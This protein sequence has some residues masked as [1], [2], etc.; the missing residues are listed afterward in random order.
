MS[1]SGLMYTCKSALD[2]GVLTKM[3]GQRSNSIQTGQHQH[4]V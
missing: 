4:V 3:Y 1:E 2:I